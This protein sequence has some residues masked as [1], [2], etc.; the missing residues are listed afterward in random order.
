MN[1][2]E[3]KTLETG[4]SRRQFLT[5]AAATVAAL[6]L[7]ANRSLRQL[8]HLAPE[9]N[10]PADD[11]LTLAL[12]ATATAAK[13]SEKSLASFSKQ[14]GIKLNVIGVPANSWVGFFQSV[15]TR[16]AGGQ[17]L[18]SAYIATE[19]MLLFEDRGILDPLNPYIAQDKST[20]D[21][22]YGDLDPHMLANFRTL[23]NI[24]ANTYFLPIGYNVMS[25]WI[26][27][28]V[29]KQYNV[30]IPSPDWTWDDFEAA[31]AKIADAPNRYGFAIGTPVP[32]PFTDVYPWVLTAGGNVMNA[33]QSKCVA[34]NP[35]A[36]EAATFVRSLVQ[37][38]LVNEPGGSYNQWTEA[39]GLKLGMFG[40]GIWPNSNLPLTQSEINDQFVIVPWPQ[41]AGSGTPIGV[42]GF[43]MFKGSAAKDAL[44]TY[45]KWTISED[46]QTG[47]VTTVGGDMPIR[48]SV[49]DS[50][51]FLKQYPPGT[52]YFTKELSYS[53]FI[54]GVPNAG[55]VEN[56]ISTAWEQILSGSTSPAKGMATMQNTCNS[57]MTQKV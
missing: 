42:G 21:A 35:Q 3:N 2:D 30:P 34:N 28:P 31:A 23:D 5:G 51:S 49:A 6:S 15:S 45:I 26:N 52:D 7:P 13:A 19:G 27:K 53:S 20:V 54:I 41:K 38:K 8:V 43:P 37:K 4:V 32:G 39:A 14:Y 47:P 17:P 55:A 18:D 48:R 24:G 36:V 40:G 22:Y 56:E 9:K 1:N 33:D 50:S 29:F 11:V 10:A 25:M 44:W 46:F 12:Y 16:L 57:L